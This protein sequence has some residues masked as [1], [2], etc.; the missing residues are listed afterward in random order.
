MTPKPRFAEQFLYRVAKN[1][2]IDKSE[3]RWRKGI[4]LGSIQTS[5]ENIIGTPLGVIKCRSIAAL[6]ED[7]RF[8]ID[9]INSVKGSPWKP[10]TRHPGHKI[11]THIGEETCEDDQEDDD[12][13]VTDNGINIE[14]DPE[15]EEVVKE[16]AESQRMISSGAG[17]SYSFYVKARDV[18]KY[19]SS[20]NCPGCKFI[21]GEVM[22][23]CGHTPACKCLMIDAMTTDKEDKHRVQRWFTT[24]G[25]DPISKEEHI[26]T[27]R[28]SKR[29]TEQ[30]A[31]TQN[32]GI[33]PRTTRPRTAASS[34][35][36]DG[37][38]D[39]AMEGPIGSSSSGSANQQGEKRVSDSA[40]D[41]DLDNAKEQSHVFESCKSRI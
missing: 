22:T 1:V 38:K 34:S 20:D 39:E 4:W 5:D 19:G 36:R 6:P 40:A 37:V 11:R 8:D 13:G 27:E 7:Q 18:F 26:A 2:R 23:Q 10:S 41:D 32:H 16:V 25:I 35:S 21:L 29:K 9:A 3:P 28:N 30:E 31:T 24:K 17:Q 33:S 12:D 15:E 14:E